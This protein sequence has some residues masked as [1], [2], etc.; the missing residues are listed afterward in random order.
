M[1]TRPL[2]RVVSGLLAL[3]FFAPVARAGGWAAGQGVWV[4][5][6][7]P[8]AEVKSLVADPATPSG[9]YL[10]TANGGIY[11]STDGGRSWSG[12]TQGIPFPGFSVTSLAFEPGRP[13]RVWAGLTGVIRGGLL[14]RSDD[15]G[16]TWTQIRRW[17]ERAASRVVTCATVGARHVVVVGGDYGLEIS[18]DDGETFR[19]SAPPLDAGSGVSFLSFHPLR[20]GVLFCGSFRHPFRSTDLGR[21]WQ[22]IANGMIEDTE[23]FA[24]SFAPE[25][26]DDFWAATCGWVYRTTDGGRSWTRY[27]EGLLDR[28]TH[29]VAHDP[30]DPSRILAGTTGGLF[31]TLD[32]GKS[33]HRVGA[34]R[35]AAD[36]A[37]GSDYVVNALAFDREDPKVLLVATETQGILRSEDG[38]QTLEEANRGLS[39]AR[40][41]AVVETASGRVV[42]ARAADGT[43]G[44]LWEVDPKSGEM[45]RLVPSP[46]AT[47]LSLAARGERLFAATPD[48][49][50]ASE[51]PGQAFSRVLAVPSRGFVS[52]P[53]GPLMAATDTGVFA[54]A[55]GGKSWGRLGSITRRVDGI[56]RARFTGLGRA[57]TIA[58]DASGRTL[59]WDGRDF[60]FEAVRLG[61]AGKL[62]GGFGRPR[63]PLL[64]TP[65][66]VGVEVDSGRSLIL[67]RPEDEDAEGVAL[68]FPEGG[69]S[70]SGWAGDPRNSTGLYVATIGR[71]LFRFV[72]R[73][74]AGDLFHVEPPAPREPASPVQAKL[75]SPPLAGEQR[76]LLER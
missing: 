38:G 67:F 24:L 65:E 47:V 72:P 56:R 41:S 21:T 69:L 11:R 44:G 26:A 19:S 31:E 52:Q 51:G 35:R 14:A 49:I 15:Q 75:V 9:F 74:S 7:L 23:V 1:R 8:G 32:S 10:G 70:I 33:F 60:V 66:P 46:P 16:R 63:A 22:R 5:Y 61:P 76:T 25:K 2:L 50:F 17:D 20:P 34:F 13:A 59:W 64:W 29:T 6:A 55:D 3:A 53:A 40:V 54:T 12:A 48:G 73:G 71:G 62:T 37:R 39:E 43:S 18:E 28:R 57:P 58:V 45:T 36:D 4:R 42:V 27:K 30:A 68:A